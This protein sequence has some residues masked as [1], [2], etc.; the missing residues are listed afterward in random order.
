MKANTMNKEQIL[1]LPRTNVTL[2]DVVN[3]KTL[4]H[5]YS[6]E[7]KIHDEYLTYVKQISA[8][9]YNLI[10]LRLDLPTKDETGKFLKTEYELEL[11]IRIM[12]GQNVIGSYRW[13]EVFFK[14][15]FVQ[16]ILIKD[17]D[18]KKLLEML[19]KKNKM[20]LPVT[21]YEGTVD[22]A[23]EDFISDEEE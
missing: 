5:N 15:G 8:Q 13:F 1:Q 12:K 17:A 6:M 22:L 2:K 7:I 20:T 18:Q 14:V 10:R 4:Q 11:P 21:E 16:T 3:K 19:E 9:L 23:D